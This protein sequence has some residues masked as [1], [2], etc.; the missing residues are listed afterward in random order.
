MGA[1]ASYCLTEPGAGS[2]AAA[3]AHHRARET[4]TA[5]RRSTAARPSSPAPASATSMLVMVPD[6]RRRARAGSARLLVEKRHARPDASASRRRRWAGARS[7]PPMVSFDGCRVPVAHRIG[8][9]GEGF[10]IAMRGLDGGRVN[11]AA[12]SLGAARA[13]LERATR[14]SAGAPPVRPAAR[15][16]PGAAVPARRH[17]DRARG[18]AADGLARG[19]RARHRRQ[20]C[21]AACAM[22]KRFATDV[23]IQGRSTRRCSCMAAMATSRT[24]G[25]S[26]SCAIAGCI[27]SS[28]GPTR[29]CG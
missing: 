4:A 14:L 29:S 9:E 12:C 18:G 17:G 6:R 10:K 2:D 13:C 16:V 26:A 8:A 19:R 7:R 11:I 28:K 22:A 20:R 25:S 24:T 21:H 23:G 3:P 5:L 15:R 27:R 1:C